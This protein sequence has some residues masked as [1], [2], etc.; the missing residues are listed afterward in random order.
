MLTAGDIK[1][2]ATRV[3]SYEILHRFAVG[4]MA[5]LFLARSLGPHG[6]EKLVVLKKVLPSLAGNARFVQLFLDEARL[7][8]SLDHPNIAHVHDLGTVDGNYFF[9]MEYVHGRDLR[10][11]LHRTAT[12]ELPLPT[13]QA[14]QIA[15][16][17]ASALHYAHGKGVVHRDVS[18]SNVLIAYEGMVKL[19]D[20]G[21]AKAATS[22][23]QTRSGSLKG[24]VAYMSP[25][26]AK[27]A[28]I[29]R[30][31]D[32]FSTGIVLW[33]MLA[34]RRLFKA[35]NDLATIQLIIHQDAAPPS[36][37]RGDCPREL[38]RIVLR[39]LAK[40]P[41]DR[42]QSAQELQ[43][44]LDELAREAKLD[45][46]P[47]ALAGHMAT[48]FHAELEAWQ[49]AQARGISLAEHVIESSAGPPDDTADGEFI[50]EPESAEALA[51]A[52]VEADAERTEQSA[53]PIPEPAPEP[54]PDKPRRKRIRDFAI[55]KE[56]SIVIEPALIEEAHAEVLLAT[57]PP[58]LAMPRP[59]TPV[60]APAP[61]APRAR[62]RGWIAAGAGAAVA[63]IAI[64]I[65]VAAGGSHAPP[66]PPASP[67]AEAPPAA[68]P[69]VPP[70][71]IAEPAPP[72]PAPPPAPALAQP[73]PAPKHRV[74][75]PPAITR[76]PAVHRAPPRAP[77]AAPSKPAISTYDP[78]AALPPM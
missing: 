61:S 63:G 48:L 72:P 28:G 73:P 5:E 42:Y 31:S 1:A 22:T 37:V 41:D 12:R 51:A 10:S 23:V 3:G 54:A 2:T 35:D 33:E 62:R 45:Q 32:V 58:A 64:A 11:V 69:P 25:E 44:D 24:K 47:I 21:V 7:A 65:V 26:Q 27:G 4:G 77:A 55:V 40:S 29:D 39:A 46:S 59:V 6:F 71:A 18:P 76:R 49:R 20:F 66:V 52:Q 56:P 53:P 19:L 43:R 15:R 78:N 67:S 34:A 70:T 57:P 74:P 16:A 68:P 60:P 9:T 36:S 50:S 13:D 8:A 75:A 38:D 30:R 17:V 14:V